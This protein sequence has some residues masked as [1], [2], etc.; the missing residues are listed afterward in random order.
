MSKESKQAKVKEDTTKI[1][2][3]NRNKNKVVSAFTFPQKDVKQLNAAMY[4]NS[5]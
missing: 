3:K 4:M 2:S 5:R 1:R